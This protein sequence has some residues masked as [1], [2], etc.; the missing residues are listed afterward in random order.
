MFLVG[1]DGKSWVALYTL[2]RQPDGTW[3]IDGCVLLPDNTP[4]A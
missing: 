1:P 3:K 2:Q 4:T